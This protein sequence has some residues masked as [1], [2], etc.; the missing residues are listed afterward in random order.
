MIGHVGTLTEHIIMYG[1]SSRRHLPSTSI[2]RRST[3]APQETRQIASQDPSNRFLFHA[4]FFERFCL[5]VE[6]RAV[7]SPREEGRVGT[8]Q[9]P[10]GTI[11]FQGLAENVFE[12]RLWKQV[13]DPAV[14]TGGVE[15]KRSEPDRR[16]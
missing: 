5:S 16:A 15:V 14:A 2:F 3:L 6:N 8:K 4:Q 7:P 13:L 10:L 9:Q 12:S 1:G 11:D